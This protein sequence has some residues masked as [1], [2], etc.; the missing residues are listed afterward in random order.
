MSVHIQSNWDIAL[1]FIDMADLVPA[2]CASEWW[3]RIG[4]YD[5][6]VKILEC[7]IKVLLLLVDD[8]NTKADLIGSFKVGRDGQD[9]KKSLQCMIQTAITVVKQADAV[10]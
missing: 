3:R 2:V 6:L 1:E 7:F 10:P 9:G 5:N 4:G 8:T